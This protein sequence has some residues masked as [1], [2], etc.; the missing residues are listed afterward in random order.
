M[1]IHHSNCSFVYLVPVQGKSARNAVVFKAESVTL[2]KLL[3]SVLNINC[4]Y[5]PLYTPLGLGCGPG[6]S[7]PEYT[8]WTSNDFKEVK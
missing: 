7:I 3:P 5:L 4:I 2:M 6:L 1:T 8:S